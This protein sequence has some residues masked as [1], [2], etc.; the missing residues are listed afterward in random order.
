MRIV[1]NIAWWFLVFLGIGIGS[2]GNKTYKFDSYNDAYYFSQSTQYA[3]Q[4]FLDG[5][6][7]YNVTVSD[8]NI[9]PP[10]LY[11]LGGIILTIQIIKS[12]LGLLA[13]PVTEGK[14]IILIFIW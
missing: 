13:A 2:Y 6:Y 8:P 1:F 10:F 9:E 5:N 3:G 7:V 11:Q 4:P 14:S 12:I